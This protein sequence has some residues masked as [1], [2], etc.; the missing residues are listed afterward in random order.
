MDI[1]VRGGSEIS[2]LANIQSALANGIFPLQRWS[3]FPG[4]LQEL[5]CSDQLCVEDWP[6]ISRLNQLLCAP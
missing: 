1:S 4:V 6:R 2:D 3:M 5:F